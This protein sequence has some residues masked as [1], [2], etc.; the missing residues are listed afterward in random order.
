MHILHLPKIF[1]YCPNCRVILMLRDGRDVAC[2]IK[3]RTGSFEQGVSRWVNDNLAGFPYWNDYR[4]KV[5]KYENLVEYPQTSLREVCNFLGEEYT[6]EML[7]YDETSRNWYSSNMNAGSH[8][9][10]RNWQINQPLFDGR[11]KWEKK[12]NEEEKQI[13]KE[14]AQ[15]YMIEFGYE[16]NNNW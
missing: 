9:K 11:K 2:S 4:V 3:E 14:Q 10:Y 15:K 13:F 1:S 8:E 6:E 7:K 12:I 16:V 5:V